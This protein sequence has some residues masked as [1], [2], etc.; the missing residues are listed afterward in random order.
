MATYC[1]D[2][3]GPALYLDCKE[4]EQKNCEKFFCLVAG[5]RTFTDYSLLEQKLDYLLQNHRTDTVIVSGGCRGTDALAKRYATEKGYGYYEFPADWDHLGKKAGIVRNEAMHRFIAEFPN[6]AVVIFW[7]GI[8]K[9]AGS[10]IA[11][12]EKYGNNIVTIKI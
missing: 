10:N 9:G 2:K 5:T 4:C 6:R 12:A 1:P 7:D 3:R 8:S 11:L